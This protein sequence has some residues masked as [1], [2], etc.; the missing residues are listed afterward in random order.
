L[1]VNVGLYDFNT[2][3]ACERLPVTAGGGLP[4]AD[5]AVQLTTL[6]LTAVPGA[7]PNPI[8][9]NFGDELELRGYEIAPRQANPGETITLKTYWQAK[10]PLTENY[11]FFAQVVDLATTTRYGSQ[12]MQPPAPTSTWE[13]GQ[14]YTLEMQIPLNE[15][16]PPDVYP[17]I[18]GAYTYSE[19]SGFN[20][21]QLVTENGR[22]TQ[23][24][25]LN[26]T[27]VRIDN[28]Q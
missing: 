21:L 25:F 4:V 12:D 6:T 10:R 7:Y 3:P 24:D 20:R 9:V 22:I 11:T 2:C 19:E 14:D 8:S 27:P 28:Q 16:I 17:I 1:T 26:L 18:L 15:A 23:D 13:P 5:D